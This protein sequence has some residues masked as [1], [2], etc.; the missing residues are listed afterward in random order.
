MRRF[1]TNDRPKRD[2]RR[3]AI[4]RH[5]SS[6]GEGKFPRAGDPDDIDVVHG[7][8]MA[9]KR[10]ERPVEQAFRD[11]LIEPTDQDGESP[12]LAGGRPRELS[13][14]GGSGVP[15]CPAS[16]ANTRRSPR[17]WAARWE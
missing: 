9:R 15:A 4:G 13:H 5:Q 2:E 14:S 10:V 6:G 7:G 8:A 16:F 1:T 17:A 11:F 3:I 12:A